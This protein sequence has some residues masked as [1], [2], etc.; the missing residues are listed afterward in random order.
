VL[1]PI[2]GLP[3]SPPL[4]GTAISKLNST[5][6]TSGAPAM[7]AYDPNGAT[8]ITV[9]IEKNGN[10]SFNVST[11]AENAFADFVDGGSIRSS[12]NLSVNINNGNVERLKGS[13]ATGYPSFEIF[14][15]V[16]DGK[17]IVTNKVTLLDEGSPDALKK[18]MK[19]IP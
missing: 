13:E 5:Q 6:G 7:S 11:K 4:Q 16:Y 2:N 1:D 15:Y 8:S 14:S 9:P 3:N 19:P 10:A 12:F 18:P 17:N